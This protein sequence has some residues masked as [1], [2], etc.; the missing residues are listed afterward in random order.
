[1]NNPNSPQSIDDP[2]A[3][4]TWVYDVNGIPQRTLIEVG[5]PVRRDP[6]DPH[7]EWS[8]PL[9]I[10][11]EFAG[12]RPVLGL[13]PVDALMNAMMLVRKFFEQTHRYAKNTAP[14]P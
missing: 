1:M 14:D 2:V 12:I 3:V 10:E 6:A 5:R 9:R 4:D 8:C 11:G 7:S 13:G